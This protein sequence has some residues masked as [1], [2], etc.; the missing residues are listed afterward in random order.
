MQHDIIRYAGRY[1][2]EH[3]AVLDRAL[4]LA[5]AQVD[6][7]DDQAALAGGWLRCFLMTGTT[8]T[9]NLA[10]PAVA[11]LRFAAAEIFT[12]LARAAIAGAV[13]ATIGGVGVDYYAA[14]D[15]D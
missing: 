2:F 13:E 1:R 9:I 12:G 11:D 3:R 8:L 15:D 14:G 6:E 5:Q 4:A 7:E 10:L